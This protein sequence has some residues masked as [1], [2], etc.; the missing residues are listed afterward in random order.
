MT[1][2]ILA[3]LTLLISANVAN[4]QDAGPE[5]QKVLYDPLFWKHELSLKHA[6]SRKIEEINREFYDGLR[7]LREIPHSKADLQAQLNVGLQER[8]V[9]IWATLHGKQKRK[10]EKILEANALQG[11]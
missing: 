11:P 3:I 4:A 10:F 2:R 7:R 5:H 9:K 1:S 8:S 6:Q